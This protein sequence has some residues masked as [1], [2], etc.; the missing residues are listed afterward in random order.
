MLSCEAHARPQLWDAT[1]SSPD[2]RAPVY[3]PLL[4]VGGP[5]AVVVPIFLTEQ[6][7]DLIWETRRKYHSVFRRCPFSREKVGV[8]GIRQRR[9]ET[10]RRRSPQHPRQCLWFRE[11]L[12]LW[13][14][15][16][17]DCL[18]RLVRSLCFVCVCFFVLFLHTT[19][20]SFS[21]AASNQG[22]IC[23]SPNFCYFEEW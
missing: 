4:A 21:P 1:G 15:P 9:S 10:R 11:H 13:A 16:V 17:S 12:P 6:S 7:Q 8:F 19:L 2:S 23:L 14:A 5:A 18:A 3:T 22:S 20:V